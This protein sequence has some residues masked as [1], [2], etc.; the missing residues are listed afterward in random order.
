[1]TE[2]NC[3]HCERQGLQVVHPL[4]KNVNLTQGEDE[5]TKYYCGNKMNPH[6]FCKH[7][8]SVMMTDLTALGKIFPGE[9]RYTVNVRMLKDYDVSKLTIKKVE[10]MKDMPPK[11]SID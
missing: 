8:G 1:M 3:S 11:Y 2:C 9:L 10:F 5:L 7:C 6:L 4:Q